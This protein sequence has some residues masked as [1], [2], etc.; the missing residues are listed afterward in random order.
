MPTSANPQ[1]LDRTKAFAIRVMKLVDS[2]SLGGRDWKTVIAVGHVSGRELPSSTSRSF[3]DRV[4]C[5][6]GYRR[7]RSG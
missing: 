3:A 5:E 4:L 6:N 7:G 1:L 2:W